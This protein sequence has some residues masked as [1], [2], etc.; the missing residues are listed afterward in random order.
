MSC[1]ETAQDAPSSLLLAFRRPDILATVFVHTAFGRFVN[2]PGSQARE[3]RAAE[4]RRLE[5]VQLIDIGWSAVH[6]VYEV[7]AKT[8]AIGRL[9]D[10]G[11]LVLTPSGPAS[12]A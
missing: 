9:L 3:D 10:D 2:C 1:P 12:R 11:R 4:A 7:D 8:V 5:F 6:V